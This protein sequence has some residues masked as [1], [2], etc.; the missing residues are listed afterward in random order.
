MTHINSEASIGKDFLGNIRSQL[1]YPQYFAACFD[2]RS[3]CHRSVWQYH[4]GSW[5]RFDYLEREITLVG[6]INFI[7]PDPGH[8]MGPVATLID[9]LLV[10]YNVEANPLNNSQRYITIASFVGYFNLSWLRHIRPREQSTPLY[11]VI[12]NTFLLLIMSSSLPIIAK[13][14]GM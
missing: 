12:L 10:M 2:R 14:L 13:I 6:V 1:Q 8:Y 11:K 9:F 5:E 7:N 4:L 3:Y